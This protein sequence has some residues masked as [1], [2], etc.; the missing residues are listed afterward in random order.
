MAIAEADNG[1][2]VTIQATTG[3]RPTDV[4]ASVNI[5]GDK[6]YIEVGGV[7]L[8]EIV[9]CEYEDQDITLAEIR[10]RYNVTVANG[11]G[12]SH[13]EI[14]REMANSTISEREVP[15]DPTSGA[16][17]TELIHALYASDEMTNW[18]TVGK[19]VSSRL[20]KS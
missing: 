7:A 14:L 6:G 10:S 13:A 12:L 16:R 2:L 15:V 9:R 8:N 4:E 17:A 19:D 11:Y 3:I 1:A 18:A 5:Y 20:G